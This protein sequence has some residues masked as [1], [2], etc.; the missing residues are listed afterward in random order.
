M[1]E[2][3]LPG[4]QGATRAVMLRLLPVCAAAL[5]LLMLFHEMFASGL[6]LYPSDPADPRYIQ[7]VLEHSWRWLRGATSIGLFDLP[8][9]YPV[10]NMLAHSEPMLS[11]APFYWPFRAVG[12]AAST[13]HQLW[14]VLMATLN[15][16]C[17]YAL[18][19]QA[20]GFDRL[21]AS[22]SAFL[23]AF[24]L[25]RVAQIGHSQLWPQLYIVLVLW[26]L[27]ALLSESSSDRTRR[28]GAPAVVVGLALQAWGSFD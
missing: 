27:H 18:M 4:L 14:T 10:P 20:L 3:R 19:R 15:F 28:W 23:F 5:G 24:G 9:G 13:S 1:A 21:A 25:P 7:F 12:L 6:A 22:A 11:F 17:F 16:G 8:M 26:G 2:V